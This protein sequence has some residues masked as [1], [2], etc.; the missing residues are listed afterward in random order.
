M[1][2]EMRMSLKDLYTST[3]WLASRSKS[4]GIWGI[5]I[6]LMIA[7][8]F[9]GDMTTAIVWP[10]AL[11]WLGAGCLL[12]A[13][14]CR[15]VHC[16]FTGPFFLIMALLSLLVGLGVVEAGTGTWSMLG[17]ITGI[18]GIVIWYGSEALLG[19]YLKPR[20]SDS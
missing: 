20:E 6:I 13:A 7:A 17:R 14:R 3:D 4:F 1:T 8:R 10:I 12:N 16:M 19:K 15:R 18:G 2:V 11:S 5:P 9:F